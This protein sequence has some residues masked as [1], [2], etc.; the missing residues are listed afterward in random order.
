M[1]GDGHLKHEVEEAVYNSQF[2]H[3]VF[4]SAES[5]LSHAAAVHRSNADIAA[6]WAPTPEVQRCCES[7]LRVPDWRP[8]VKPLMLACF[9]RTHPPAVVST[10]VPVPV[11][12]ERDSEQRDPCT[13]DFPFLC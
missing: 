1:Q 3:W 10:I 8:L 4:S 13:T 6:V 7:M 11:S 2:L 12:E 9:V 5:Q